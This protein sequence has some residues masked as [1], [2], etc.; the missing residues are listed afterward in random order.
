MKAIVT[1]FH[2]PGNVKGSRYSATDTDGNRVVLSADH[3]LSGEDNH[4]R[5][6]VALCR[7]MGWTQHGLVR[8]GITGGNVYC[9][10]HDSNRLEVAK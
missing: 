8:G 5:A 4:D 1:K 9:F 3:A 6:A 2:G 10:D 7:K